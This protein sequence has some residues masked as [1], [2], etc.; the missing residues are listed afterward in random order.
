MADCGFHRL[1]TLDVPPAER[2]DYWQQLFPGLVLQPGRNAARDYRG[3]LLH[4]TGR[5]STY[6][7]RTVS[8]DTRTNFSDSSSNG[9]LLSAITAGSVLV[10]Y[11]RDGE[12]VL[13]AENGLVLSDWTRPVRT[14]TKSFVHVYL[15]LPRPLV[16]AALGGADVLQAGFRPVPMKGLAPFLLSQLRMMAANGEKLNSSEAA[17]AMDVASH[18]ALACLQQLAGV[19]PEPERSPDEAFLRAAKTVIEFHHGKSLTV[20]AIARRIGCSR[21]Y[22]YRIFARN[23]LTVAGYRR[24]VEFLRARTLLGERKP[25]SLK[26][27]AC[28]CGYESVAAFS[29]AFKERFG[30]SPGRWRDE[31]AHAGHISPT[32]SGDKKS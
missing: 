12:R 5:G 20:D 24:E 25:R 17:V 32:I 13:T 30:I 21:A 6:F 2:F 9:V 8:D 4:C 16:I 11:G 22:L 3:D 14:R 23:G 28:S 15:A 1:T 27:I 10:R 26:W 7:G 19:P 18:L 29:R 31:H